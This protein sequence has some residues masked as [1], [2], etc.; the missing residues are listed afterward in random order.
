VAEDAR[1]G[2]GRGQGTHPYS[3]R[4]RY[5]LT[6][7]IASVLCSC[8][9]QGANGR[10]RSS[11]PSARS[12]ATRH[13]VRP[14]RHH[15]QGSGAAQ[16]RHRRPPGIRFAATSRSMR[17]SGSPRAWSSRSP[18]G[19]ISGPAN[20][21]KNTVEFKTPVQGLLR[22][23]PQARHRGTDLGIWSRIRIIPLPTRSPRRNGSRLRRDPGP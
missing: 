17:A 2:D 15:V 18:A 5:S 6:G 22:R 21:T 1:D 4:R 14:E 9:T 7:M 19:T 13:D 20:S 16:H 11:T 23:Q 3:T 10:A 8:S 12:S